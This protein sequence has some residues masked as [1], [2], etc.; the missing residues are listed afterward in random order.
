MAGLLEG[1]VWAGGPLDPAEIRRLMDEH[2]AGRRNNYRILYNLMM[3][4][5]WREHYPGLAWTDDF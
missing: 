4:A 2:L 1:Q 3:F 5:R